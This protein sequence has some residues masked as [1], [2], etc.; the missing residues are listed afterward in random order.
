MKKELRCPLCK[1]KKTKELY[2]TLDYY[3]TKEVFTIVR[4]GVCFVLITSPFPKNKRLLSYYDIKN[5]PSYQKKST[6]F[7]KVYSFVQKRNNIYNISIL[8]IHSK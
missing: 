1:S 7:E 5:Y 6:F 3:K 4:C 8:K 2:K